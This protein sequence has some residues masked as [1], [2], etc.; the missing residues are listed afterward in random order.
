[1]I[2]EDVNPV[3][4]FVIGAKT[5]ISF[6]VMPDELL[7]LPVPVAPEDVEIEVT[8][9]INPD[10]TELTV[11]ALSGP[12]PAG[13]PITL[14]TGTGANARSLTVFTT[15]SAWTNE[16]VLKVAKVTAKQIQRA[17]KDP[18]ATEFPTDATGTYVAMLV[19]NGGTS[20]QKQIQNSNTET[21]TFSAEGMKFAEGVI[22]GA[23]WSISMDYNVLP[24]D[25]GFYRVNFA[26]I[27]ALDGAHGWIWFE[28][29][30][31]VGFDSGNGLNGLCQIENISQTNPADGII[32]GQSQFLG[33]GTPTQTSYA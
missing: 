20:A 10:E 22:T 4:Q 3:S 15:H 25:P 33:R 17:M 18:A 16:T 1:M 19:I 9:A 6:S 14:T 29:P 7:A 12:V 23:S 31:P 32:T 28:D 13:T 11:D 30:A 27:N 5:K 21:R 2:F 24:L 26:T 8:E